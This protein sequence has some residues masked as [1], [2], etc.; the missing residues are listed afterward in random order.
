MR[1][2]ISPRWKHSGLNR[3]G[4]ASRS[5]KELSERRQDYL[6]LATD[7]WGF[8]RRSRPPGGDDPHQMTGPAPLLGNLHTLRHSSLCCRGS[9][10]IGHIGPLNVL[11][12]GFPEDPHG[13]NFDSGRPCCVSLLHQNRGK[14]HPGDPVVQVGAFPYHQC[15]SHICGHGKN[16]YCP[17]LLSIHFHN[18]VYLRGRRLGYPEVSVAGPSWTALGRALLRKVQMQLCHGVMAS[19]WYVR[20]AGPAARQC[21]GRLHQ[22]LSEGYRIQRHQYPRS[23]WTRVR[24]LF[25]AMLHQSPQL[26]CELR[27]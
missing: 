15:L 13:M 27:V 3:L 21:N 11:G 10:Q 1:P 19:E 16:L 18:P 26:I 12:I 23:L 22:L 7:I 17:H 20:S 2:S 8:W 9:S 6:V 24:I 14:W 4:C 5:S 25:P